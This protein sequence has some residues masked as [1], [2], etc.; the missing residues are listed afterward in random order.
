MLPGDW[1]VKKRHISLLCGCS[2]EEAFNNGG[3]TQSG[4]SVNAEPAV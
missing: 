3:K 2:K 1:L 4:A